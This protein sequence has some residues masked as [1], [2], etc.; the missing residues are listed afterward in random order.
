MDNKARLLAGTDGRFTGEALEIGL[1]RMCW[2][3]G[4]AG[5]SIRAGPDDFPLLT[6]CPAAFAATWDRDL[7]RL[8]G[9]VVGDEAVKREVHVIHAPNVNLP[10]SPLGGRNFEQFSEDPWLTGVLASEWMLGVQ[11]RGV[12]CAVKHFV[13]NDSETE[14]Q[15]MNSLVNEKVLREVYLLPFELAAKAGA[16]GIMT[17]YNRVNGVYCSEHAQL[18]R[19]IIKGEWGFDGFIMSDFHATHSTAPSIRAGL[20]VEMPGPPVHYGERLAEAVRSGEISESLV[21]EALIRVLRLAR[22]VGRLGEASRAQTQAHAEPRLI[23]QEAAAAGFVL[24]TNAK[25]LL[26]LGQLV[27]KTIA[28]IGPHAAQP[29]YQGATFAQVGQRQDLPTPLDAIRKLYGEKNIVLHEPGVLPAFRVPPLR[30]IRVVSERDHGRPGMDVEYFVGESNEPTAT[31]VRTAGNF[32][33][34][35]RMPG[36][37][38][39]DRE[40]RVRVSAAILP[41]E[42]GVYAFHAGSSA[43]F[44]LRVNGEPL[45]SQGP[46]PPLDDTAV[47]I[48][49]PILSATKELD[50]GVPASV[51]IEMFFGPSRAHSLHF[52]CQPPAPDDLMERA[53]A[54]ARDADL[55]FLIV[56]E[57][58][59]TSVESADRTTTRLPGRQDELIERVCA[60]NP[61]TVLIL[62]ASHPIDMPWAD[63]PAALMH[64]WFPGQEFAPALAAVLSG[65]MEP[66]GRL[67]VT[68]ARREADYPTFDLTPVNHDLVYESEPAIAYGH[69]EARGLE[70]RFPFGHGLSYADFAYQ[71][72]AV[73]QAGDAVV[74]EV[75]VR[76]T[77]ARTGKEV[78]QVYVRPPSHDGRARPIELKGFAVLRLGPGEAGTAAIELDRRAFAHWSPESAAW[79]VEPGE[80]EILVGRSS[81][82]IR[83]RDKTAPRAGRC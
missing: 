52:G 3:D 15:T 39:I 65:E 43:A 27:G 51:E 78:V 36:L 74:V 44:E 75:T 67:P 63:L 82:D 20:D 68:F 77:S 34:N 48:R 33:W 79:V 21:D 80:Y 7:V 31:E 54:A 53:V 22:R 62:N 18:L 11:S 16:W 64:V 28:V 4:P 76:N 50:A 37:D 10:R 38:R 61:N 13:C 55:V 72:F 26:P 42:S 5:V 29:T 83:F 23:L 6:P 47:A 70:A 30:N 71:N 1:K 25:R 14:R 19:G 2:S 40:G 49:P 59:D 32:I 73:M 66:G 24:L 8:V 56:G 45:L 9:E 58:Q 81:A 46:Q 17:A 12:A 57:T 35:L 69:F 41:E 60:A